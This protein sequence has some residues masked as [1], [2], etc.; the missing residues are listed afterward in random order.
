MH[1]P[2]EV[3]TVAIRFILDGNINRYERV[4]KCFK[5]PKKYPE[6]RRAD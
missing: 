2:E 6:R 1:F 5:T 3:G 4:G